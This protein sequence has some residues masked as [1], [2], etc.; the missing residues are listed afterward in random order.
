MPTNPLTQPTGRQGRRPLQLTAIALSSAAAIGLL[1]GVNIGQ[2][3]VAAPA[4]PSAAAPWSG[5]ADLIEQVMPSVVAITATRGQSKELVAD[6]PG[7]RE[8]RFGEGPESEMMKRFMERFFRE[9]MPPFGQPMPPGQQPFGPQM[10]FGGPNFE[11]PVAMGSGFV[12]NKDGL[13]VTNHHVVD[14]AIE[15][16]VTLQD[17]K[18]LTGKVI[19]KDPDTDLALVRVEADEADLHPVTFADSDTV[20]VGDP[21]IAIG[22]PFGLGGTVT[23]GIVSADHR[24]IGAGRYDD[25]LQIDA[26]INRGNSGGPTFNLQGEVIGVNT[27]IH[28]PSG[29]NVGIGFAIP[30]NLVKQ[31][32]ADLEDDG[33]VE[34]GWLG[35]HIQ[36]ID[37]DLAQGLGLD[38]AK[39]ALVTT[40]TPDSPAAS[41]GLKRGDVV[42]SFDGKPIENLRDLTRLVA[43]KDPGSAANV[44]VWR[45]GK[46][47]SLEVEIGQMP[48]DDEVVA[49]TDQPA[50]QSTS[51]KIGVALAKLT[52]EARQSLN[53]PEEATGVVVT[54]VQPGSPAAEKGLRS[55]DVIVE[56][57]RKQVSDPSMVA[58]AVREAAERGDE[59]ILL[60]VKRDG[61][62]RFVAVRLARA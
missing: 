57:D 40:V 44:V 24:A 45:D 20:R 25:F 42:R 41:A 39:G 1:A 19:G 60:L 54:E 18:E 33:V 30:A 50:D 8:F 22:S 7:W 36:G 23:A 5:Y 58:E 56:A 6:Q 61:Q 21:V 51:P 47:Q 53:L 52:P 15:V 46:E 2:P 32:V 43:D 59:T 4:T 35:V 48:S 31:V 29:G 14:G 38:S 37:D 9:Q 27:L 13:I 17:G 55:G 12:V 11:P 62:D 26:P 10:P 16:T 28:S 34:R 49:M 3:S